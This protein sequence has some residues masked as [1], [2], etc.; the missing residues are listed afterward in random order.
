M[1]NNNFVNESPFLRTSRLFPK[2]LDQLAVE[3]TRSYI[4]IANAVNFRII[5][6]FAVNAPSITGEAWYLTNQRQNT[7]RQIF[8]FKSTDP[9][10]HNI[11]VNSPTQFVRAFGTYTD[12]TNSY[13]LIYGTNV[14]FNGQI[15]FYITSTQIVFVLNGAAPALTSGIIDLEWLTQV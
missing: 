3:I 9:I 13:G 6:I 14:S 15:S 1:M 7:L 2:D 5:S 8:I 4:D 10:T 12:G 11:K